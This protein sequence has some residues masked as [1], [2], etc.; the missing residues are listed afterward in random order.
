MAKD[1]VLAA[2]RDVV[3]CGVPYE[4]SIVDGGVL[5]CDRSGF[6]GVASRI[7]VEFR[8]GL[9]RVSTAADTFDRVPLCHFVKM[10]QLLKEI[11]VATT[12]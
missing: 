5:F 6:W 2:R 9:W 10:H 8:A 12:R 3:V 4:M 1:D 7:M 11:S